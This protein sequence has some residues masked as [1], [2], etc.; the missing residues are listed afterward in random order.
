MNTAF[1]IA[2]KLL[3]RSGDT[4]STSRPVTVI[5]I[6]GIALG[7]MAMLLSVMIVT[8]FRNEIT[9]KVTGFMSHIRISRFDLNDSFEESPI[10]INQSFLPGLKN[11]EGIKSIQS[12]AYKAGILKA[13]EDIQ[14]VVLK[15]VSDDFDWSFFKSKLV[16]GSIPILGDTSSNQVLISQNI[17]RRLNLKTGDNF[18]VFFIQKDRKVRKFKISGIYKT[19]LSEDFDNLYLLC[20]LKLIQQINNWKPDE[21]G[22][23]E[24]SLKEFKNLDEITSKIY[25]NIGFQYNT[26][27]I[28]D[29][30]PQM[31]NWLEL[32]NLNVIVIITLITLVAGITMIS[33]LLILVLENSKQIGLLKAMGGSNNLISKIFFRVA[34]NILLKG[35]LIGNVIGLLFAFI[36]MKFGIITLPEESYYISKVPINFT[37]EGLILI[38]GSTLIICSLMLLIPSLIIS[39]IEPIKAIQFD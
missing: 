13:K 6:T 7:V 10:S 27:T 2:G 36:Q 38:N 26:Q 19:G 3:R 17:A 15:G 39:R 22:G 35:L 12:Y 14:G 24:I 29:L 5:A 34:V 8:G 25:G 20:D 9:N 33:T 16:S 21:V 32:Q 1:Y 37:W 30:Y 11:I 4:K 18:L 31:F 28:K 23:F